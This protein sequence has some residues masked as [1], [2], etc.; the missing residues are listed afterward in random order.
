MI[1]PRPTKDRPWFISGSCAYEDH[2]CAPIRVSDAHG[3][4]PGVFWVNS[5]N[6]AKAI[7][8]LNAAYEAGR[9]AAKETSNA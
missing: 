1:P 6:S 4:V 5:E 9:A 7:E 2:M 8:M 3:I